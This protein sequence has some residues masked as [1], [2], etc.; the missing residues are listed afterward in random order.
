MVEEDGK[1]NSP[2]VAWS[3]G[4]FGSREEPGRWPLRALIEI[5]QLGS[6]EEHLSFNHTGLREVP[7]NS[8]Q[9]LSDKY[10]RIVRL[11]YPKPV[12]CC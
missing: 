10:K 8:F 7:Y 1:L 4:G 3:S 6:R 11:K 12:P 2:A 5:D 9:L